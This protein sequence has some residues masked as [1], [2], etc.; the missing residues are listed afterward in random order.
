MK[1]AI[2]NE[3]NIGDIIILQLTTGGNKRYSTSKLAIG[4]VVRFTEKLVVLQ[5]KHIDAGN[6]KS[7]M[8]DSNYEPDLIRRYPNSIIIYPTQRKGDTVSPTC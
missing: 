3:I 8:L 4:K 2:G 6:L 7:N 5:Y 1:D